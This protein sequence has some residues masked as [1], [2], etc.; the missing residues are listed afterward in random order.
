MKVLHIA[1]FNGNIGDNAHHNGFRKKFEDL[2]NENIFWD[3]LEI[4]NFYKSWNKNK[5]DKFFVEK[6]NK[7]DLIIIG[8]GN[9]FEIC[10]EYSATGTTID[11]STDVLSSIK[12]PIFFNALGF[13]IHKGYT[14]ETKIKFKNFLEYLLKNK[15]K[16]F[17]T[18]R[19]DG[20]KKNFEKLYD[21]I[22]KNLYIV[23]D[24]GFFLNNINKNEESLNYLGIN[25]ACD[26]LEKRLKNITY[27]EFCE[28]MA[29][30][31]MN[32]IKKYP[33]YKLIFFPHIFT[34]YKI[35]LDVLKY[36]P[37]IYLKYNVEVAPYYTGQ[38]SEKEFFNFYTKCKLLTGM[39]FHT[40][41]CGISLNI[42]TIGIKTYQKLEDL[43]EEI[44]LSER[45]L[46]VNKKNFFEE[47]ALEI[48][49]SI[50]NLEVIKVNYREVKN[51]LIIQRKEIYEKLKVWLEK[52]KNKNV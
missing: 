5:F 29:R 3:N 26:M 36:F 46:D 21:S 45:C 22:P 49:K 43:Y 7:Y 44:K 16:Y 27:I 17:I 9:F 47:Y 41:V 12:T 10:H 4:R 50:S 2:I 25:L 52:V 48:E 20:S 28:Q 13:D 11:I 32:F 19:N 51:N 30:I 33:E 39:R 15:E 18:F 8:G 24:G 38:G 31:Y 37:D 35:I 42:P 1:S 14:E 6:A 40:N 34:D 23:P